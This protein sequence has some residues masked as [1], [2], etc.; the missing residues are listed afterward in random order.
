MASILPTFATLQQRY[1]DL[2]GEDT[3]S[4]ADDVGQRHINR[5]ITDILNTHPFSWALK[6]TTLTLATGTASL[7]T[8]Y[9]PLWGLNDARIV[10]AGQDTDSVFTVIDREDRDNFATGDYVYYIDYNSSSDIYT[11][12][13]L[14]QTGSVVIYY[15]TISTDLTVTTQK[16]IVPEIEAVCYLAAAKNWI[17]NERNSELADIY[18]KEALERIEALYIKDQKGES[19]IKKKLPNK[20]R[21]E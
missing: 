16:C 11:F 7:P 20:E 17:G 10:V 2:V 5:A 6:T 12:N 8:D 9:N 15:Y 18:K 13:T 1:N 21:A 3:T 14:T 4:T 19:S